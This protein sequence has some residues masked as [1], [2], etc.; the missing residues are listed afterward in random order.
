M[1]ELLQNAAPPA[2]PGAVN[3]QA[4]A[5]L[6]AADKAAFYGCG[7]YGGQDTLFD[8]AGR[9]YFKDTYI[10][11]TIDFIFGNAKSVFKVPSSKTPSL[12]IIF[13]CRGAFRDHLSIDQLT[14]HRAV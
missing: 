11:G 7:M 10:S 6:L 2:N 14:H 13:H 12:V 9:H 3:G 8:Y 1:V 4:V 5:V